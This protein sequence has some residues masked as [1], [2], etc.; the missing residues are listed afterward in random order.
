M[1][2]IPAG[3][4]PVS[5]NDQSSVKKNDGPCLRRNNILIFYL[6]LLGKS[7]VRLLFVNAP[8]ICNINALA[9]FDSFFAIAY[10]GLFF[11]T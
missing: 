2:I 3:I 9:L 7:S 5:K 1:Q 6:C 11:Y 10:R 8:F 4:I